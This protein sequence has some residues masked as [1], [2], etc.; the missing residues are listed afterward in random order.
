[1]RPAGRPD[2]QRDHPAVSALSSTDSGWAASKVADR[3]EG[4]YPSLAGEAPVAPPSYKMT[5]AAGITSMERPGTDS[6]ANRW[7]T[8]STTSGDGMTPRSR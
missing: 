8:K 6:V 5:A 7:L 3:S 4:A 2:E 1:M